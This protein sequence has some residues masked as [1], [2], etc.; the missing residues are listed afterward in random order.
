MV[1][2]KRSSLG[3]CVVIVICL[4]LER[5]GGIINTTE[6]TRASSGEDLYNSGKRRLD[7]MLKLGITT[8]EGNRGIP[9][10]LVVN[11]AFMIP[12][13]AAA[14]IISQN[15]MYCYLASSDSIVSSNG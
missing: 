9:E 12:Q 15:K 1:I 13:Y 8:V 10:F 3:V 7:D 5:D 4:L 6:T 11:S 2:A 14:S